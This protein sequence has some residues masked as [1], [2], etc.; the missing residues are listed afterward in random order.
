VVTKEAIVS[1]G[2]SCA[3]GKRLFNNCRPMSCASQLKSVPAGIASYAT[4]GAGVMILVN[5]M[6]IPCFGR[7]M[8]IGRASMVCPGAN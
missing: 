3:H 2:V 8:T 4:H 7:R 1:T 5:V 6:R